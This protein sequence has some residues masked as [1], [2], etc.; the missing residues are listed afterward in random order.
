MS[1]L[2]AMLDQLLGDRARFWA[3]LSRYFGDSEDGKRPM[4]KHFCFFK[5]F[6][7]F[8]YYYLFIYFFIYFFVPS[9]ISSV[10][11]DDDVLE[12]MLTQDEIACV[13]FICPDF[14]PKA[15]FISISTDSIYSNMPVSV[16]YPKYLLY[17]F[18]LTSNHS[19]FI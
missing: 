13:H 4:L 1:D 6:C 19:H 12:N 10:F 14:L 17:Q 11:S 16:I 7:E 15:R 9:R 2:D 5:D 8:F 18:F 3:E